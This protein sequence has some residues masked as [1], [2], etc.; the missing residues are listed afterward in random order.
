MKKK[1]KNGAKE[2]D[3]VSGANVLRAKRAKTQTQKS[4]RSE[5][6]ANEVSENTDTEK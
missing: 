5:Q 6:I 4:E 1:R 2:A 3:V